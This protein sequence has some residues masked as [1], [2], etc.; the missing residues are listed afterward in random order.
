MADNEHP[1]PPWAA[2]LREQRRDRFWSQRELARRLVQAADEDTRR[3]LPKRESVMRLIESHEAGNHQPKDPYRLLYCRVFD[4]AEAELFAAE[5][6]S[7]MSLTP[8]RPPLPIM[9]ARSVAPPYGHIDP[10]LIGV[11]F[12]ALAGFASAGLAGN[13]SVSAGLAGKRLFEGSFD[14]DAPD[15]GAMDRRT[16]MQL[17]TLI[18]AGALAPPDAVAAILSGV[19]RAIGDREG[20]DLDDWERTAWEYSFRTNTGPLGALVGDLTADLAEVG[21]LLEHTA[22]PSDRVG[23]LR[24]TA[25]LAQTLSGEFTHL[26]AT[27][28]AR[29]AQRTARRAADVSGDRDLRVSIRAADAW[30][31]FASGQPSQVILQLLDDAVRISDGVPS[32]ALARTYAARATVLAAQSAAVGGGGEDARTALRDLREV[33]D[34]LPD[35][36]TKDEFTYWGFSERAMRFTEA[37]VFALLGDSREATR[38]A[39]RAYVLYSPA[40]V[41]GRANLRLIQAYSLVRER[42]VS[43]GLGHALTSVQG[44]PITPYRRLI[45]GRVIEALPERAHTLAAARELSALAA[46]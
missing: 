15:G 39:E 37:E 21:R 14:G 11:L 22:S 12:A 44:L 28:Q 18:G 45:V 41:H 43:D 31:S 32:V 13:D 33:W 16:A 1:R 10:A 36:D 3:T 23:L 27:G 17:L 2:R 8:S 20:L 9:S 34:R 26:R 24:V 30:N 7:S 35:R 5:D 38:A 46:S 40:L 4:L 25:S 6:A 19:D 42:D 29:R